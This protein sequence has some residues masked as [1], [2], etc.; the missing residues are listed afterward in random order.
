MILV[1]GTGRDG[2]TLLWRLLNA[3]SQLKII[4]EPFSRSWERKFNLN[5]YSGIKQPIISWWHGL[6]N[7]QYGKY[8][9]M[10]REII[11]IVYSFYHRIHMDPELAYKY[12]TKA[13][14]LISNF[15]KQSNNF[16]TIN[17]ESLCSNPEINL[18]SICD[19]LQID[20]EINMLNDWKL[21]KLPDWVYRIR[22]ENNEIPYDESQIISQNGKW[23]KDSGFIEKIKGILL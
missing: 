1:S 7:H 10:R 22:N 17:Y 8:I 13:Q 12:V 23:K 19:Y 15:M 6:N 18:E 2:T 5:H 4:Y 3:H 9:F 20:F 14:K 21:Q 11:D 16:L